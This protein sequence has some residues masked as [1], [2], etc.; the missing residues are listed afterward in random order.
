[1]KVAAFVK[2]LRKLFD[3]DCVFANVSGPELRRCGP[4]LS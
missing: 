2:E 3:H 4:I 1:M